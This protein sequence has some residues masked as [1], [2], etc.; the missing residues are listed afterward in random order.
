MAQK[1]KRHPIIPETYLKHFFPNADGKG[2]YV[3]NTGD[4]YRSYVQI[5][6]SG[7]SI[8]CKDR[9]LQ[10]NIVNTFNRIT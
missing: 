6:N 8:F 3:I 10:R 5:K 2:I 4:K 9:L 7:D 1:L